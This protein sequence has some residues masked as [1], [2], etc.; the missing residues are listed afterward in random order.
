MDSAIDIGIL[1][2]AIYFLFFLLFCFFFFAFF[3]WE[4]IEA[5][6]CSMFKPEKFSIYKVGNYEPT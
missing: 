2:L 6:S 4:T 5:K 3:C 1:V